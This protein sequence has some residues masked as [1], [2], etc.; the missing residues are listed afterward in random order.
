MD[1]NKPLKNN[2]NNDTNHSPPS[3]GQG[4]ETFNDFFTNDAS[5]ESWKKYLKE[6]E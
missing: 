3:P 5:R 1:E 6:I 2:S 4:H